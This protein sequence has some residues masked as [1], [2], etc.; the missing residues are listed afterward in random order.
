M[1][2]VTVLGL[3]FTPFLFATCQWIA[4]RRKGARPQ[5]ADG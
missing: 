5:R 3:L 1:I 4:E 2:G